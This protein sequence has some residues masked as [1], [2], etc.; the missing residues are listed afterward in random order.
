MMVPL[1]WAFE[2]A[3][4]RG[5]LLL[6]CVFYTPGDRLSVALDRQYTHAQS[7]GF[8][9]ISIKA[10]ALKTSKTE[11]LTLKKHASMSHDTPPAHGM[12]NNP[13]KPS[14]ALPTGSSRCEP[15]PIAVVTANRRAV[16]ADTP[17]ASSG[18]SGK[19]K[20]PPRRPFHEIWSG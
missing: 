13:A 9:L 14:G 18:V 19:G 2:A 4:G 3:A 1:S 11:S 10:T 7:A 17:E 8:F 5:A 12:P 15:G 16:S 6:R 20:G